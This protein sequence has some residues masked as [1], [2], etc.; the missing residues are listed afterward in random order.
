MELFTLCSVLFL[1]MSLCS[2][3]DSEE[4][5]VKTIGGETDVTP[6]C[7]NSTLTVITVI[8][9]KIRTQRS[10]E[11]CC[12]LY[13]HERGFEHQC[14]SPFTLMTENQTVFLHLT[15]LTPVDSGSY[16]CQCSAPNGTFILNLNIT[17]EENKNTSSPALTPQTQFRVTS[18]AVTIILTGAIGVTTVLIIG[19]I[20]EIFYRAKSKGGCMRSATSGPTEHETPGSLAGDNPDEDYTNLQRPTSDLYQTISNPA[21][22]TV[23]V[24]LDNLNKGRRESDPS[25]TDYENI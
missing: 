6:I 3:S 4:T 2:D 12:L 9:C 16:T 19:V 23:T 1:P 13:Q 7:T 24:H 17:V 25:C 18:L 14:D 21:S 8:I 5:R 20:L 10:K 15:A 11:E 22:N